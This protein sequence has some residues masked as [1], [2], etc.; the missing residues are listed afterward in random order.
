MNVYLFTCDSISRFSCNRN[1]PVFGCP[2]LSLLIDVAAVLDMKRNPVTSPQFEYFPDADAAEETH[3]QQR[4]QP[5]QYHVGTE[6]FNVKI[7]TT[8]LFCP[9]ADAFILRILPPL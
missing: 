2:I 8:N 3:D 7:C 6:H 5:Q 4:E 1:V 9:A